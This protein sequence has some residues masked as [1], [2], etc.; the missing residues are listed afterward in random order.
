MRIIDT[1]TNLVSGL[2]VFGKDKAAHGQF[3]LEVLGR[4]DLDAM[5]RGD[6]AAGKI[7]DI[8]AFDMTRAWRSWQADPKQITAIEKEEKRLGL[9]RKIKKAITM[10]RLYGGAAIMLDDG[11]AT[12]EALLQPLKVTKIGGLKQI[13]VVSRYRLTP[14]ENQDDPL[15]PGYDEPKSWQMTGGSSRSQVILH[16]SRVVAFTGNEI[17]EPEVSLG[18]GDRVWG[19]SVLQRVLDAVRN[20][21]ATDQA[22]AAL[23]QEAKVDVIR[24]PN[25]MS[26]VGNK[27]YRERFTQKAELAAILKSI[28]NILLID[29]EEE[30]EQKQVRLQGLPDV[31]KGFLE[32]VCAAADIPAVRFLNQSPKGLGNGG[33]AEMHTH[34]DRINAEQRLELDPRL[35]RIDP[36]LLISALG[37]APETISYDWNPLWALSEVDKAEIEKKRADAAKIIKDSGLVPLAALQ[38]GF[39]NRLIE[40][41]TYPGL[42]KLIKEAEAGTLKPWVDEGYEGSDPDAKTAANENTPEGAAAAAAAGKPGAKKPGAG[43]AQHEVSVAGPGG[44]TIKARVKSRDAASVR[45]RDAEPKPLYVRRDVVNYRDILAWARDEGLPNVVPGVSMHVTLAYSKAPVDWMKIGST[46]NSDPQGRLRIPPGGPRLIERLGATGKAVVLSFRSE[47][48]N[49]EHVMIHGADGISRQWEGDYAPH[50]TLSWDVPDDFDLDGVTPYQ[51]RIVLGP[52]IFEE[53][54]EDWVEKNQGGS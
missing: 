35:D 21:A 6:W 5:Y 2:G 42:E 46:W 27:E 48:L 37:S 44:L 10:A 40:D 39:Q 15:A 20:A 28:N 16:P 51:G 52:Q 32:V 34:A 26:Q 17:L 13:M 12:P 14:G 30:W 49:W 18:P 33:D 31:Q 25:L 50:I 24:V 47:D 19:D 36:H 22:I 9:R 1:L 54:V 53:I 38:R 4:N 45:A 41:G 29:K 3:V 43:G 23:L 7:V 11:A 8:P